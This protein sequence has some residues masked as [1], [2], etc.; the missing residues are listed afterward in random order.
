MDCTR[1]EID[2][3]R[4]LNNVGKS[5]YVR[6][7]GR[8]RTGDRF[9]LGKIDDVVS[10]FSDDEN[11]Y[12]LQRICC[13]PEQQPNHGEY[14]YRFA[15]YTVRRDGRLGLGGQYSPIMNDRELRSILGQLGQKNWFPL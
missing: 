12:E 3:L 1:E 7:K 15:Y 10:E 11:K 8:E 4:K 14:L 9:L 6:S 2:Q 13:A 5:V